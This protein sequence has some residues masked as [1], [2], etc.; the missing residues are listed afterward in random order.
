MKVLEEIIIDGNIYICTQKLSI[1]GNLIY[2]CKEK[3]TKNTIFLKENKNSG[4]LEQT[5]DKSIKKGV[6][7]LIYAESPDYKN[8]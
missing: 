5:N 7:K 6:E 1:K 8:N 3:N 2:V 4:E